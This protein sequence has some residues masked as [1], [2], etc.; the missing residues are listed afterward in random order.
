MNRLKQAGRIGKA[1][2]W[3]YTCHLLVFTIGA[4][5]GAFVGLTV[6]QAVFVGLLKSR[7]LL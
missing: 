5:C 4:A 1:A 2:L 3:I 7:G 6:S